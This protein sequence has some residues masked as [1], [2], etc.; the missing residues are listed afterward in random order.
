MPT[1]L[2]VEE[3]VRVPGEIEAIISRLI[4]GNG[5]YGRGPLLVKIARDAEGACLPVVLTRGTLETE[6]KKVA[7]IVRPVKN[8]EDKPVHVPQLLL[9]SILT[10]RTRDGISELRAMSTTPFLRQ[11]GTICSSAGYDASSG[12]YLDP[13]FSY[14]AEL[15]DSSAGDG[16]ASNPDSSRRAIA[17]LLEPYSEFEF[18]SDADRYAAISLPLT[19]LAR[20]AIR[21]DVPL[22]LG[23]ATAPG[24]GKTKLWK[25]GSIIGTGRECPPTK[26]PE[27]PDELE[28][29]IIS[30]AIAA[31]SMVLFDNVQR[32]LGGDSLEMAI[33]GGGSI[34][35]RR[36][37]KSE[38]ITLPWETVV[39]AT[40]NN[41][42]VSADMRDRCI[43]CRQTPSCES[44]SD[45]VFQR[46][47]LI[48]W[49]KER[50]R[51]LASAGLTLLRSWV[52]AGRPMG[53]VH[54]RFTQ[55][56]MVPSVI[57]WATRGEEGSGVDITSTVGLLDVPDESLSEFLRAI[58]RQ[59]GQSSWKMS[60]LREAAFGE[61]CA[62]SI[63]SALQELLDLT[64]LDRPSVKSL[65]RMLMRHRDRIQGGLR[66]R[67]GLRDGYL[68]YWVEHFTPAQI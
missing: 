26:L 61:C 44:P 32:V 51:E 48:G 42:T 25:V 5:I 7:S 17:T 66:L 34:T 53:A 37:G 56:S 68:E 16:D 29:R 23:D 3:L 30:I 62:T 8:G 50:R 14:E 21:G 43:R 4:G 36:L 13:E 9:E 54:P 38:L 6:I 57:E 33:T 1:I 64:P 31:P 11:D 58:L 20:P 55:W 40:S 35:G 22:F 52:L 27:D 12:W 10:G 19:L 59:F 39:C 45:R 63:K 60:Q 41:A 67:C 18:A 15:S 24:S 46:K 2:D 49:V 65:G 47:D 28:K